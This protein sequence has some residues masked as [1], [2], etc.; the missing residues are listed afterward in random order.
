[1]RRALTFVIGIGE[2][3]DARA[4]LGAFA[5]PNAY[6]VLTSFEAGGRPARA[7]EYLGRLAEELGLAHDLSP[8]PVAALARARTHAGASG[9][10]VVTGSTFAVAALR[11]E[12]LGTPSSVTSIG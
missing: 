6:F 11:P 9:I 5:R 3:K 12:V 4:I 8:D 1:M 2:S 7:P 10:V